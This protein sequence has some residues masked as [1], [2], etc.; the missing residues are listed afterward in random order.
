MAKQGMSG[1]IAPPGMIL[2]A[3]NKAN[4]N[5]PNNKLYRAIKDGIIKIDPQQVRRK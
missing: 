4:I 3:L 5:N 2:P 1:I